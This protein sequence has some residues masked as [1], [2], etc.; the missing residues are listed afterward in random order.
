M[1]RLIAAVVVVALPSALAAT[2]ID[3]R[4][5]TV[6]KAWV[7]PVDDLAFDRPVAICFG[8]HLA[9]L[10]PIE[11]V[12][13]QVEADVVFRIKAHVASDEDRNAEKLRQLTG[14]KNAIDLHST[15]DIVAELPDGTKLWTE[16]YLDPAS[17]A[18]VECAL[19][20]DLLNSL[21]DAM[22]KARETK[23]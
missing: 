22:K 17:G 9:K 18:G 12:K 3:P 11:A 7:Q 15:A 5:A 4:L 2:T 23:Q 10:T 19:A 13:T 16:Q 20:D 1:N 21:R 6:R 14:G 8:E